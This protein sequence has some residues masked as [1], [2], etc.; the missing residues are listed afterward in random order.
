[1]VYAVLLF[2]GGT[3]AIGDA[4]LNH[5]VKTDRRLWLF[6]AFLI[7]ICAVS[8]FAVLLKWQRFPF[9]VAVVLGLLVHCALAVVFDGLYF[10]GQLNTWQ[11]AG[12]VCG[13]LAIVLIE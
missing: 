2:G 13:I 11:W 7:W 6:I 10:G 4:V 8:S 12:I 5:W 3:G 9:S 1:M